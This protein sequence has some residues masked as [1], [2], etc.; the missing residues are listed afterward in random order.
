MTHDRELAYLK[1]L[2]AVDGPS[3]LVRTFRYQKRIPRT[4]LHH[5][6]T[7]AT[8]LDPCLREHLKALKKETP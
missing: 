3:A 7:G 5:Y 8:K 4:T 1:R 2:T 6:L